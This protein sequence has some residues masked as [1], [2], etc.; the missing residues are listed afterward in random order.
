MRRSTSLLC[1]GF[2]VEVLALDIPIQR[3]RRRRLRPA[4]VLK[5]QLAIKHS[6]TTVVDQQPDSVL[7]V[8]RN[9]TDAISKEAAAAG[10]SPDPGAVD[11]A[12]SACPKTVCQPAI[13]AGID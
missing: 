6:D 2:D 10:E 13:V 8:M 11:D 7:V 1:A 5:Q 3:Y 12:D 9:A 4:C